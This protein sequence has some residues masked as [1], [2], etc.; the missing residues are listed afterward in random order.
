MEVLAGT[1]LLVGSSSL[2]G[3]DVMAGRH[4]WV[5]KVFTCKLV[6]SRWS[7]A[8]AVIVLR[9]WHL[10]RFGDLMGLLH[11]Y[12]RERHLLYWMMS[13]VMMMVVMVVV[14]MVVVGLMLLH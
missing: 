6:V 2:W 8:V 7:F 4:W 5:N 12:R 11:R 3:A 1:V 10:T 9:Q 14:L 13:V